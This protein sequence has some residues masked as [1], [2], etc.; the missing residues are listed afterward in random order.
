M[1]VHNAIPSEPGNTLP[2]YIG[3]RC[4]CGEYLMVN[5]RLPEGEC[6]ECTFCRRRFRLRSQTVVK[7]QSREKSSETGKTR[8]KPWR[9]FQW[10]QMLKDNLKRTR[11]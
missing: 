10:L 4:G 7:V 6:M 2:G 11:S 8:K 1:V 5:Q 3:M 9:I